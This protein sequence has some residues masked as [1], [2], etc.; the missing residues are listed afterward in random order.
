MGFFFFI[1]A[2]SLLLYQLYTEH[3]V[4]E[5]CLS[6][7]SVVRQGRPGKTTTEESAAMWRPEAGRD[8]AFPFSLLYV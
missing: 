2:V 4:L 6:V 5:N 8:G 7:P 1:P 3:P